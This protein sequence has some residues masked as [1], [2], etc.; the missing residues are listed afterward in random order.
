M[1]PD[2]AFELLD[3]KKNPYINFTNKNATQQK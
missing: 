2:F 1:A 3:I